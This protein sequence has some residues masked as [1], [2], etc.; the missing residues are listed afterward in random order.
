MPHSEPS[1]IHALGCR[2]RAI[3]VKR[4]PPLVVL[5]LAALCVRLALPPAAFSQAWVPRKGD[6][7]VSFTYQKL[8][9]R[10]HI[11]SKGERNRKV[12][13][14]S[15]QSTTTEFGY[16]RT[17]KPAFNADGGAVAAQ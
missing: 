1:G 12:G 6:G 7:T 17:D 11:D 5:C 2:G 15:S 9:G 3:R 16:G 10:D 8:V 13:T 14:D 4:V